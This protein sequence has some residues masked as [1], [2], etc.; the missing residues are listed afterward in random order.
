MDKDKIIA[1]DDIKEYFLKLEE[2]IGKQVDLAK[3]ARKTGVDISDDI[4]TFPA[5]GIAEKTEVLTGPKGV[6]D[7]YNELWDIHQN[8]EKVML[9]IFNLI[10]DRKL[11]DIEDPEKRLDQAI[12]TAIVILTEAVVVS[13]LDGI[14]DIKI[15][16]NPDGSKYIDIYFA[17][18][19]RAA[20]GTGQTWPLILADLAR[21]KLHLDIYK[22][23]KKEIDRIVEELNIYQ[24]EVVVRQLKMSEEEMRI[25]AENT[26]I[27]VNSW[28]DSAV[29][30]IKNRDLDR[31]KSNRLR[32]A[33]CLVL[34]DGVF[35][36]KEKIL[37]IARKQ[38]LNWNWLEKMI[39]VK[40][41][42][43][44]V[45]EIKPNNKYLEGIAAGRPVY[46]YPST[47]GAFRLRYGKGRNTGLMGKAINPATMYVLESFPA[48]GTHAKIERPGKACQVFPCDTIDGPIVKLNDGSI[49]RIDTE[50]EAIKQLPNIKEILFVGDILITIGDFKKS[51]HVL[52]KNGY[53][54]E[55]WLSEIKYLF[56][57][58]NLDK[59]EYERCLEFYK[60][61]TPESAIDLSLNLSVPL[62]PKYIV[63]YDLLNQE[64]LKTLIKEFRSS[65]KIFE[66]KK[67]TSAKINNNKTIKSILE[68]I[69]MPHKLTIDNELLIDCES[70]YPFLKTI[71][72][73]NAK[74][75]LEEFEFTENEPICQ[76][77]TKISKIDIREKS[78][79]WI[80]MR[81]GKPE[82]AHERSM[83]GKP[84]VLF[85]IGTGFGNNRDMIRACNKR[86][87]GGKQIHYGINDVEIKSFLCPSCKK[88]LFQRYCSICKVHTKEIRICEKCKTQTH[89]EKCSAC[90]EKTKL[91]M[92]YKIDLDLQIANAIK[93]LKVSLPDK[94]KALKELISNTK[95][96]EPLEKGVLRARNDV[97]VFR[98]GT[99]RYEAVNA[100]VTQI[101]AKELRIS[102][103][104]LKELGYKKDIYGKDLKEETQLVNIFPQDIIVDDGFGEYM[105]R[106]CKFLDELLEKFYGLKPFYNATK[107]EDLIGELAVCLAPHTSA[108]IVGR[109]IGFSET[110]LC[111][112][113]P[114]F[115]TAKRRNIDGDQ[116]SLLLLLDVLLNF[117]YNYLSTGRGGRMDVVLSFTTVLN[118]LEIDDEAHD[119]EVGFEYP[120]EFYQ[121]A[122]RNEDAVVK[123][124][125]FVEN[126]LSTEAQ[127][128]CVGF[129]HNTSCFDQ[130][131]KRS[132]Y[133]TI[134]N[135]TDKVL[136]VAEL[137]KKIRPVDEKNALERLITS[138]FFPDIIGNTRA[139]TRQKLRCVKCNAKYRRI[140]LS[141]QCTCGG[142]LILTIAEGSIKKYIEI[143]RKIINDYGLQEYLLQ[144][145]NLAEEEINDL[146]FNKEDK[147]QKKLLDFF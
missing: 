108:G 49:I 98:D 18:P 29:E 17:G 66:D 34:I 8:R 40:K 9:D 88:V 83:A 104:K 120:Y 58:N 38:N 54:E 129:T 79:T 101:S 82:A 107:K 50:E 65:N 133:I 61:P 90:G 111:W 81:M 76:S 131:P 144:R 11:G 102:L 4:E 32:E 87:D 1:T 35:V 135:M 136:K 41:T 55:E 97:Y 77:L 46:G 139:F 110:K 31:I 16:T 10:L 106:V 70:T 91:K 123:G 124:L 52:L 51:G 6:A 26:P 69:G 94:L 112:T 56:K 99:C 134:K 14:P 80:G 23:S 64:E 146:F 72:A 93:N 125:T 62:F 24:N 53:V 113:H 27:C 5:A 71:G 147:D 86:S 48:V 142:K 20:G 138:H 89:D 96:A 130:G 122:K 15:S 75:P 95:S 114:Y 37:K 121:A 19:I 103:E 47:P 145:V 21:K 115:V 45:F 22:P 84:N 132:T 105:L 2:Q 140:P 100:I 67:I 116:D 117:S 57:N 126:V 127:Y 74:D 85:P 128:T 42:S 43:E 28:P 30:V 60:K 78:G 141:G 143:T 3:E 63:Y 119:M 25:I 12:R 44:N 68:K 59:K 7:K 13:P 118:P 92:D 137:Q 33:M 36:R 109:I 39:K 73:I